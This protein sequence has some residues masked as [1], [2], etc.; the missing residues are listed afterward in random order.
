MSM[1][2]SASNEELKPCERNFKNDKKLIYSHFKPIINSESTILSV[3]KDSFKD[4]LSESLCYDQ[5]FGVQS[6]K[7]FLIKA[8]LI[9]N[10]LKKIPGERIAINTPIQG[11]SAD[12]LKKAMVEID[13]AFEKENIK[14]TMLLQVHDE[15]I[16]DVAKD[17]LDKMKQIISVFSVLFLF[18]TLA[19]CV[20]EEEYANT[21]KERI[22]KL[23][24]E[25][26]IDKTII[27][28][29]SVVGR[30]SNE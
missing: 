23:I 6:K 30:N 21:P 7:D 24:M 26:S 16:F 18:F 4:N 15:L 22:N 2:K 11:S 8:Y 17:E 5:I 9:S 14:S 12:I 28:I 27:I 29:A 25:S 3:M 19:S 1:G 13:T 10:L 20:K